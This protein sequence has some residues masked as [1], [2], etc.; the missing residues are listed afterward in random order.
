MGYTIKVLG[1]GSSNSQLSDLDVFF[2]H[3]YLPG[4]ATDFSSGDPNRPEVLTD[5][6]GSAD[7]TYSGGSTN[8]LPRTITT[9]TR[10]TDA[11]GFNFMWIPNFFNQQWVSA[12]FTSVPQPLTVLMI[13]RPM[14]GSFNESHMKGINFVNIKDGAN[15]SSGLIFD[16]GLGT[17]GTTS[18]NAP[19]RNA[20]H[21][22][23]AK[24]D[25]TVGS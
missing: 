20:I 2:D 19:A 21:Y 5:G 11:N 10:Y 14:V 7:M 8:P 23:I 3:K 17:N 25:S 16:A 13:Y 1:T 9:A 15:A 12:S 6:I 22:Y 18:G 4:D 24:F